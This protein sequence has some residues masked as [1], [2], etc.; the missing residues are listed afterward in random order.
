MDLILFNTVGI[1]NLTIQN[2]EFFEGQILSGPA[3]K[4]SSS[5]YGYSYSIHHLKS[6]LNSL[7]FGRFSNGRVS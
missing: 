3:F 1:W 2:P 6:G 5:S 7:E 4:W